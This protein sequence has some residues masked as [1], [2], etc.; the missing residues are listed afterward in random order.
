MLKYEDFARFQRHHPEDFEEI[1]AE[2]W[3]R[4]LFYEWL[5][6][7]RNVEFRKRW[8]EVG[9]TG[10]KELEGNIFSPFITIDEMTGNTQEEDVWD[11]DDENISAFTYVLK[12]V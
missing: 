4:V 7:L 3:A 5:K 2:Q 8:D 6:D 12:W 10:Q 9:E 1:E 11:W